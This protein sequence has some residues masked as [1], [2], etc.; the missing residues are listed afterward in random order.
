MFLLDRFT[1]AFV[2]VFGIT[3][4]TEWQRRRATWFI[5]GMILLVLAAVFGCGTLLLR[6]MRR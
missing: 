6:T 2:R 4:P 1:T 3:E 5:C